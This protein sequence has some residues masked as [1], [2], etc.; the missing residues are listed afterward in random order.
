MLCVVILNC[1]A[2]RF[3]ADSNQFYV[4]AIGFRIVAG[5]YSGG[6][7]SI[8]C[9]AVAF[10][11]GLFGKS[12][13]LQPTAGHS[14]WQVGLAALRYTFMLCFVVLNTAASKFHAGNNQ[15]FGIA[16]GFVIAAGAYSGGSVHG[17]LQPC[18]RLWF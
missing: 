8:G 10:P 7:V 11:I 5:A 13:N 6:S 4:L 18:I 9:F 12:F 2:S 1:A 3:H 16:F 14:L 15:F 17:A